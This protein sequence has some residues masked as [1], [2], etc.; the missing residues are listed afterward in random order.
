MRGLPEVF[1]PQARPWVSPDAARGDALAKVVTECPTG[2]LTFERHDGGPPETGAEPNEVTL[3][4]DGPAYLR[5]DVVLVD[6]QGAEVARTTRAALCR[7]GA[8]ENKPFCDGAHT[9]AGFR[10]AGLAEDPRLAGD[11]ETG[12]LTVKIAPNGPLILDGPVS[13]RDAKGNVCA[14]GAKGALC[15][16]GESANKPFC[17]GAHNRVG[18]EAP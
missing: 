10:D 8:S 11:T 3:A 7:C 14:S 13:L 2:A 12:C 6:S 18:F 16:C 15:R 17:D 4:A 9:S 1:D 5:G